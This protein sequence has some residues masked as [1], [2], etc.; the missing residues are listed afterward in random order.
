[1]LR[2]QDK[3]TLTLKDVIDLAKTQSSISLQAKN[4]FSNSYWQYRIYRSAKLPSLSFEGTLPNY[5]SSIRKISVPDGSDIF[6]RSEFLSASGGFSLNQQ[7]GWTGGSIFVNSSLQQLTLIRPYSDTSYLSTPVNIGFTQPLFAFNPYRWDNKIEP[8]KYSQAKQQ[9]LEDVENLCIKATDA[10]FDL[11][12]AQSNLESA[13]LNKATYDTLYKITKGRYEI[14]TIA[15]NDLLQMELNLLNANQQLAQAKLDVQIKTLQLK[16][17]LGIKD[18]SELALISPM[19]SVSFFTVDLSKAQTLAL[20]NR[21]S[22]IENKVLLLEAERDLAKA[23]RENR[24]SVNI[25]GSYGLTQSADNINLVYDD[26]L[27][28]QALVI[29]IQVPIVDWGK[30]KAQIK[31]A[32]SNQQLVQSVVEQ[33][34]A[35]FEQEVFIKVMEFNMQKDQLM[36]AAKA[37]TVAHKRFLIAKQRFLIG[38][39]DIETLS[40]AQKEKETARSNYMEALR[41]YWRSYFE[42]RRITLYDFETNQP[43]SAPY[44]ALV[45]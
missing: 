38:K 31:M 4:K 23:R 14:G 1:M 44:D 43:L 39:I 26:P 22:I 36:I 29:G 10:F 12:L 33:S 32:L 17:L 9:Y 6:T 2:G 3:K 25:F 27:E 42:I 20:Q 28:Q 34:Q 15:E 21:P 16:S 11:L 41:S 5:F 45:K 40:L 24:F 30:S 37:D 35:D 8:L 18:N 7:V 13:L 19:S